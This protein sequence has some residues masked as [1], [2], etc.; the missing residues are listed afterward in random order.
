MMHS[1]CTQ[2]S[3]TLDGRVL[4]TPGR[5]PL[6]LP[7]INLAMAIAAEWDAQ[8]DHRRGIQ[9]VNMP[10]MSLVSTTIDQVQ[11]HRQTAIDTCIKYLPTDAALFIAPDYDR[12]L[13]AQQRKYLAPVVEWAKSELGVELAT[14]Q[15][16]AGRIAH[17][18]STVDRIEALLQN[19][20]RYFIDTTVDEHFT[21]FV[22]YHRCGCC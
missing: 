19:V 16:M 3:I 18:E 10:L 12:I 7:N 5:N 8:T 15:S 13:V 11:I 22:L 1:P 2:F 14:T 9:P 21:N 4:K 20:V 17:P 6:V